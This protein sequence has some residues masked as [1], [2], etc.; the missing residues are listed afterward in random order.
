MGSSYFIN[1]VVYLI[2]TLFF[3]YML[4]VMLRFL[5]QWVHADFFNPVSRFIVKVTNPPVIPLRRIIPA[6]GG[7]D[8]ASLVLLLLLAIAKVVLMYLIAGFL[9]TPMTVLPRA[10]GDLVA[11]FLNIYLVSI[12]IQ[13]LLSWIAPQQYNPV[14]VLLYQLNEPLLRPVRRLLPSIEGFDFSPLVV[15]LIIQLSK[16]IIL[17]PIYS[18]G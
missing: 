3:L 10:V 2:E 12:I 4:A 11:L 17:P 18:L 8:T 14:S 5:L 9:I 7:I 1:P 13:V 6:I 15:I 16:M